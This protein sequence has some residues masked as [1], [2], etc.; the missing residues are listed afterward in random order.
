MGTSKW[1]HHW[2]TFPDRFGPDDFLR[3]VGKT[4]NQVPVAA[5]QLDR[6]A[7]RIAGALDLSAGDSVLDLCCGN[8][9]LT[10][11][12]A[13]RCRHI[14]GV[15]FSEPL[16]GI[17]RRFHA[18]PGIEYDCRSVL[19]LADSPVVR[20]QSFDK[21]YLYEGLQHF[22]EPEAARLLRNVAS[23]ALEAR[24]SGLRLFLG[25]VPDRERLHRFYDTPERRE[26]YERRT[27][28]GTEAIGTWWTAAALTDLAQSAGFACR[29]MPQDEALYTAHYRFDALLTLQRGGDPRV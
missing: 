1:K 15:D 16:I 8:G 6:I 24:G 18:G 23:L 14:V 20:G 28:E 22:D 2:N 21:A 13:G 25:S 4:V 12:L 19:E 17:A 5:T 27:R 9:L 11:R 10:A 7:A 26:E 29:V 3:Q